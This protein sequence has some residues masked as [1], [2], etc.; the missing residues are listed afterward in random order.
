[1][2]TSL[3]DYQRLPGQ[4]MALFACHAI[5]ACETLC[6][7]RVYRVSKRPTRGI[8][9]DAPSTNAV[10][11]ACAM[12]ICAVD[13]ISLALYNRTLEYEAA[14]ISLATVKMIFAGLERLQSHR[15]DARQTGCS[16]RTW[17]YNRALWT[18]PAANEAMTHPRPVEVF[19]GVAI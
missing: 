3:S 16:M 9:P 13:G 10:P 4:S 19:L 14:A 11:K 2:D 18:A 15:M 5:R 12:I 17:V 7:C 1:M 8:G 6:M